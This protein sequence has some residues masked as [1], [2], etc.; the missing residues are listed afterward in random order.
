MSRSPSLRSV[1][2]PGD[3]AYVWV[4]VAVL[5]TSESIAVPLNGALVVPDRG[6]L[7]V[8]VRHPRDG[9]EVRLTRFAED[10]RCHDLARYSPT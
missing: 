3:S 5:A 1:R 9:F 8:G 2:K 6:G 4:Y 10:V 7:W